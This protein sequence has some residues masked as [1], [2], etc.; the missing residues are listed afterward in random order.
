MPF[1]AGTAAIPCWSIPRA[2]T[3]RGIP[4]VPVAPD[5][6]RARGSRV[7]QLRSRYDCVPPP[8][9]APVTGLGTSYDLAPFAA[10]ARQRRRKSFLKTSARFRSQPP[11]PARARGAEEPRGRDAGAGG[12][13]EKGGKAG[14]GAAALPCVVFLTSPALLASSCPCSPRVFV[15]LPGPA[16]LRAA[17]RLGK[18]APPRPNPVWLPGGAGAEG[19]RREGGSRAPRVVHS[20]AGGEALGAGGGRCS[21]TTTA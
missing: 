13:M 21:C 19:R 1:R 18:V 9:K 2:G 8:P 16:L 7:T 20:P 15:S 5:C 4:A 3:S 10:A 17:V 6:P 14:A 11:S 12:W